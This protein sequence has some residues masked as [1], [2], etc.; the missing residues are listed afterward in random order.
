MCRLTGMS[1]VCDISGFDGNTNLVGNDEIGVN[2]YVFISGL[3]FIKISTEDKIME[4]KSLMGNNM[5]P[6][7]RPVGEK[8]TYFLSDHYKL[9]ENSKIEERTS[10]CSTNDSLEPHDYHLAKCDEGAFKTKECN[11]IHSFQPKEEA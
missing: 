3:Q 1:V 9:S 6:T 7:A 10:L 11:Q 2:E 4:F 5:I 8:K